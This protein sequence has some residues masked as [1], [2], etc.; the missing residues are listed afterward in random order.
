M[1]NL[2]IKGR[3]MNW[4]LLMS[5]CDLHSFGE[6]PF[7]TQFLNRISILRCALPDFPVVLQC[8]VSYSIPWSYGLQG[9]IPSFLRKHQSDLHVL[10]MLAQPNISSSSCSDHTFQHCPLD[11][12]AQ[13]DTACPQQAHIPCRWSLATLLLVARNWLCSAAQVLTLSW[14]F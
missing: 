3:K 13:P 8:F 1:S 7:R 11:L 4:F 5:M 12:L 14:C 2:L 10:W 6:L 9:R